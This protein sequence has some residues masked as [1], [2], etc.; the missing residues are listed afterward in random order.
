MDSRQIKIL[1]KE[2]ARLDAIRTE[3]RRRF[4]YY[5]A[6]SC[7]STATVDVLNLIAQGDGVNDRD[8]NHIQMNTLDL[9]YTAGIPTSGDQYNRVRFVV[10][11][12]KRSSGGVMTDTSLFLADQTTSERQMLSPYKWENKERFEILHD[13]MLDLS[14]NGTEVKSHK[15]RIK[16]NKVCTYVSSAAVIPTMNALYIFTFSDSVAPVH[17]VISFF[18]QLIYDA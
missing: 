10:L 14:Y 15:V 4:E 12:D 18:T 5:G 1:R 3:Q 6:G 8:G 2:V 17:P 13:N 11:L 7:S 9:S 16:I